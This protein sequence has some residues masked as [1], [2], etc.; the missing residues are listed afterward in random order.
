MNG[1]FIIPTGIGCA[2]GGHAG[3][4]VCSVNLVASICDNLL[5]N[6]NAVNASD[7]N[8]MASNCLYVEGSILDNFLEGEYILERP[9]KNKI[10]LVTNQNNP[11]TINSVNAARVSLGADIEICVLENPLVMIAKYRENGSA[12]GSVENFDEMCNQIYNYDFDAIAIQSPIEVPDSI[13][14]NYLKNGGV[15]PWGGVEAILSKM[16]ADKFK[17]PTAHAPVERENSYFSTFCGVVNSRMSAECVSVSYVHCILKGLHKAPRISDKGIDIV[18]FLVSPV[19]WGRPHEA[20]KRRGIPII[21]VRDNKTIYQEPDEK[22]IW[23]ENYLEAIGLIQAM[24]IGINS[25][26]VMSSENP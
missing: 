16:V 6:P 5:V 9:R 21:M 18:D 11:N 12:G 8:E 10:L 23:A 26:M 1:A 19:C 4:A 2:I 14:E 15:N 20:C 22:I 7:I 25:N 13:A 24:K 17:V 3:D